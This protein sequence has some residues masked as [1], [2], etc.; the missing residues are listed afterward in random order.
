MTS[1][2]LVGTVDIAGVPVYR[3][4]SAMADEPQWFKPGVP[5]RPQRVNLSVT[6]QYRAAGDERW[7]RGR[8]EN[9]SKTGV[10]IRGDKLFSL[11][12]SVEITMAVPPGIVDNAAGDLFI[13]GH[14]ARLV[15]ALGGP[16]GLAIQFDRYRAA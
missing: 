5:L 14:V 2:S 9:I 11:N 7:H 10:L 12:S 16:P 15:P 3:A 13:V 4:P 8:T 1:M 6:A